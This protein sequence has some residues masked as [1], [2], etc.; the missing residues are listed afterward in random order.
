MKPGRRLAGLLP[1]TA[2]FS[3]LLAVSA[4]AQQPCTEDVM[5]IFD[6]SKSMA[7][8]ND[9]NTGLRRIDAVRTALARVLPRVSD[10]R[11]IGLITY[12]PGSRQACTNVA[13]ELRPKLNAGP[14]IMRRVDALRPDGRTPLTRAVRRAAEVLDYSKRAATIVLITDGEE[15]CGGEPC[16]LAKQ[17]KAGAGTIVHVISYHIASA[18]G[19]DGIFASKCLADETG[20]TYAATD[21]VDQVAEALETALGCPQVSEAKPEPLIGLG[22]ARR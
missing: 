2:A 10:K 18:I 21:T 22:A 12:G 7:A 5:I 1:A 8:S 6:A 19:A 15:T 20:G 9:D 17:L 16:T 13:L 3:C 4:S 11:R 14:E